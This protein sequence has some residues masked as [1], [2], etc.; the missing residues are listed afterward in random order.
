MRGAPIG[1]RSDAVE[2]HRVGITLLQPPRGER[3]RAVEC[4]GVGGRV[5]VRPSNGVANFNGERR[6]GET[7]S[8]DIDRVV[9]HDDGRA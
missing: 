2:G 4:D 5:E 9:G 6:W 3:W 1:V 8:A 7:E